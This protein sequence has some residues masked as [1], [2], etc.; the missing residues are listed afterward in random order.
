MVECELP[1]LKMRVRILFHKST[2]RKD[3][4]NKKNHSV[5]L[6]HNAPVMVLIPTF[7]RVISQFCVAKLFHFFAAIFAAVSVKR[8]F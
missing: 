5:D 8:K 4:I 3:N 7:G 6:F 2:L 1:K